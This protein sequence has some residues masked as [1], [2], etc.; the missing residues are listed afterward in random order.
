[1]NLYM[2]GTYHFK[3]QSNINILLPWS[4]LKRRGKNY[5]PKSSG[6]TAENSRGLKLNYSGMPNKL[7][8]SLGN[9]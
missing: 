9:K 2:S 7:K 8:L 1:L 5:I 6:Q 4:N 3:E